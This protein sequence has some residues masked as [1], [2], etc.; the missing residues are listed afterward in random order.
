MLKKLLVFILKLLII[1]QC[2]ALRVYIF[3]LKDSLYKQSMD[4]EMQAFSPICLLGCHKTSSVVAHLESLN[5]GTTTNGTHWS[6]VPHMGT[7]PQFSKVLKINKFFFRDKYS[8]SIIY[9][10]QE[11]VQSLGCCNHLTQRRIVSQMSKNTCK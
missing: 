11:I 10:H 7:Q 1:P 9:T 5:A 6:F 3:T 4:T 8:D 2:F